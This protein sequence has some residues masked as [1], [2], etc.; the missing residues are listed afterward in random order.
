M[1][2][3]LHFKCWYH[4][5]EVADMVCLAGGTVTA[6]VGYTGTQVMAKQLV[7]TVD[8]SFALALTAGLFSFM[9]VC[10][11]GYSCICYKRFQH[12]LPPASTYRNYQTLST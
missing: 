1:D 11:T 2:Q 8:Y 9:A 7:Y 4:T 10:L 5:S 12:G 6:A 3:V